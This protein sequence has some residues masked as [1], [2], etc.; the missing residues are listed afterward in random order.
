MEHVEAHVD[1]LG[2][3]MRI[4]LRQSAHDHVRV[5][6]RLDLVHV[7]A[8]QRV[9]EASVHR[10]EHGDHLH[11]RQN[12]ARRGEADHVAEQNRAAFENLFFLF[13]VFVYYHIDE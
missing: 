3:V 5:A 10:V 13:F 6:D 12:A 1:Y 8:F 4:P 2:R 9:V 7:V 11:G